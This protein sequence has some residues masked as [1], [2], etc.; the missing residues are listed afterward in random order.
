MLRNKLSISLH[1]TKLLK[2]DCKHFESIH[3]YEI[4]Y[5]IVL[6]F[7]SQIRLVSIT[8]YVTLLGLIGVILH[9]LYSI[10]QVADTSPRPSVS[11]LSP[12]Y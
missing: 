9:S 7:Y 4:V 5:R 2:W 3:F 12:I 8:I 6:Y 11:N 10:E 1:E